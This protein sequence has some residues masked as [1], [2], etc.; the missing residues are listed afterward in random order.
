MAFAAAL[1]EGEIEL[2]GLRGVPCTGSEAALACLERPDCI[3]VLEAMPA[4]PLPAPKVVVDARMRKK[5]QPEPQL[6]EAPLV[7]GI[8]P[9]F[10]AGL[11]V[12]AVVES[13]WGESLGRV[14]WEGAVQ[15]YTGEHRKVEGHGAERY[16]YAPHAGIFQTNRDI[17]ETVAAGE[18]VGKVE[19]T[20]L[21]LKISGILRGL[22]YGGSYVEAGA[23]LVEVDPLGDITNCIGIGKRPARIAEGVLV[24][25]R[26]KMAPRSPE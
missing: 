9:G 14:V 3:P 22:A 18:V 2:E 6:E 13:N 25:I 4:P 16:L 20:P 23:K 8:G 21:V 12:H 5:V 10:V 11:Q 24:A 1:H 7:I 26:E 17:L 19:D 15:D